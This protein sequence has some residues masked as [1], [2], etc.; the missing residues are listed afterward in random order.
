MYVHNWTGH[1]VHKQWKGLPKSVLSNVGRRTRCVRKCETFVSQDEYFSIILSYTF[2]VS[3]NEPSCNRNGSREHKS[4]PII[5][6][7]T[8]LFL[9]GHLRQTIPRPL[10]DRINNVICWKAGS[11]YISSKENTVG[12][13]KWA[14]PSTLRLSTELRELSTLNKVTLL[15]RPTRDKSSLRGH[16]HVVSG[17]GNKLG[18]EGKENAKY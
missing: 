5:R 9:Y 12:Q 6:W 10:G 16:V 14:T 15:C 17:N 1:N 11:N 13:K 3:A 7:V 8:T 2:L 4:W 18:E